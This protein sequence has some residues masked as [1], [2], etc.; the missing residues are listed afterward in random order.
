MHYI[1]GIGM[2]F[3]FLLIAASATARVNSNFDNELLRDCTH[4]SPGSFTAGLCLGY[5]KGAAEMSRLREKL[6]Q[7]PP[8]CVPDAVTVGQLRNIVVRYLEE[9]PEEL[10]YSS[11]VVLN[12]ALAEAFPCE[13]QPAPQ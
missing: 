13:R 6:P 5:L 3:L 4:P 10:H 11:I 1:K 7:L 8:V 2:G 9:H 12:N